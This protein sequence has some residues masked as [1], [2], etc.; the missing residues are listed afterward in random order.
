MELVSLVRIV[1]WTHLYRLRIFYS[2]VLGGVVVV[3]VVW[4]CFISAPTDFPTDASIV[5]P[6][7]ESLSQ[8]ATTLHNEHVIR[9]SE[10]FI[11]ITKLR[12]DERNIQAGTYIFSKPYDLFSM[13]YRISNGISDVLL[14]QITFIEGTTVREMAEQLAKTFPEFSADTFLTQ[15]SSY[16][17]YLFP[18]T[19][20]FLP[21]VTPAE[22]ITILRV[23]FDKK[24]QTITSQINASGHTLQDIVTMASI[25][26]REGRG[27]E[28]KRIIAGVL[29]KR[30]QENMPLQVDAVFGYIKGRNTY[31]PSL[32]D[33]QI[34]S[35]YNT[36]RH[37][38]LPPGPINNPGLDSLTAAVTPIESDYWYYLTGK[39]GKMYYAKTFEEHKQNR[40]KYLD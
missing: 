32:A 23:T 30:V 5:L 38:G 26:E 27:L 29:W 24:T 34:D 12:S 36:Y 11:L 13:Q 20:R 10:L 21:T 28:E 19:Y 31:S 15:A 7:G 4:W 6:S 17:G 33:L 40:A 16:E 3:G 9:S 25:L 18:D 2:Y 8:I 39:D 35:P 14:T 22:I 1:L 37:K